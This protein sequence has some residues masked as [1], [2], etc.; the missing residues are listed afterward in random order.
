M[1][2]AGRLG[3]HDEPGPALFVQVAPEVG[4]PQVVAVGDLLLLVHPGQAEGQAA[5]VLHRLGVDHVHV[6][7][8]IGHDEIALAVEAVDILVEGVGL[9][10]VAFQAMDGEVHLSEA[11]GGGGL[12]LAV[13]GHPVA[14]ILAQV[15]DE[16]AGLHE[17]SA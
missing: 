4:D 16:V 1:P 11:D 14:G 9:A 3:G 6:E 13:E 15:L 17:H 8:R 5:V 7:G 2:G 12:L 10:D